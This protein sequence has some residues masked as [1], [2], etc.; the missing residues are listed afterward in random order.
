MNIEAILSHDLLGG[1]GHNGLIPWYLP[2]DLQFFKR[3]TEQHTIIMGW[4]T[5]ASIRDHYGGK[6]FKNRKS[7]V[8]SRK[9]KRTTEEDTE[10]FVYNGLNFKDVT[11]ITIHQ[12]ECLRTHL[13][14]NHLKNNE[15]AYVIGGS[16][17]WK[18]FSPIITKWH[19]TIVHN[20]Y[21]NCDTYFNVWPYVSKV[22]DLTQHLEYK[23]TQY[24]RYVL[25]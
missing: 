17:M 4:N 24:S 21:P 22:T 19:V 10:S 15:T 6:A 20:V 25:E 12:V 9:S 5:Y 7:L 16:Q 1:V 13:K 2:E 11:K 23:G 18:L 3:T 8:L 14:L